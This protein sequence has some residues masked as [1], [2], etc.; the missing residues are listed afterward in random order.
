VGTILVRWLVPLFNGLGGALS[1][2]AVMGTCWVTWRSRDEVTEDDVCGRRPDTQ[3]ILQLTAWAANFVRNSV[4]FNEYFKKR[5]Y[6]MAR[7]D[8]LNAVL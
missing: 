1:V 2:H 5:L 4:E 8:N 7:G 3:S 6:A